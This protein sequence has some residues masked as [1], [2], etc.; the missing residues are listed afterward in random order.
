MHQ[1]AMFSKY[2]KSN[3]RSYYPNKR[4]YIRTEIAY[5][6]TQILNPNCARKAITIH[7][8]FRRKIK[9]SREIKLKIS[10]RQSCDFLTLLLVLTRS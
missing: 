8:L 6:Q 4:K 10:P 3:K 9:M 7:V 5:E 1:K 2:I